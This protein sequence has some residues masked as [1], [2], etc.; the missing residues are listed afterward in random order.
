M[1]LFTT[2]PAAAQILNNN[3]E[4]RRKWSSAVSWL[5]DELER[6][7]YA[8][9]TQYGYNNWSPP[10]QSNET[11]NGYY[12]ERSHSA[13]VTLAKA[14]ELC[15][16]EETNDDLE[17]H[18]MSEDTDSPPP[19]TVP[20]NSNYVFSVSNNV[21]AKWW[22]E[23]VNVTAIHQQDSPPSPTH[24]DESWSQFSPWI[25]CQNKKYSLCKRSTAVDPFSNRAVQQNNSQPDTQDEPDKNQLK[26][27]S[28][29]VNDVDS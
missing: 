1:S 20:A 13:R 5:N 29:K 4:L 6:R 17:E 9:N 21:N 7:P 2:C 23:P 24:Q 27:T 19:E 14:Y 16:A 26:Q 11:S 10:A 3:T 28:S 8:A 25:N 18:D 22:Q 15:P 12:L